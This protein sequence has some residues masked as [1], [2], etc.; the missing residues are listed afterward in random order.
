ML[1]FT[2][3]GRFNS[4]RSI[5]IGLY[6]IT[7]EPVTKEAYVIF[8]PP[9]SSLFDEARDRGYISAGFCPG[10]YGFM[11]KRV[12]AAGN[13]CIDMTGEGVRV[14]GQLLDASKAMKA[15]SAGRVMPHYS[16]SG[17]TLRNREMLLM[18]D[19]SATSFDG[20]YFGPVDVS[21]IRGVIRPV[22][23]W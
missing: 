21:Q 4:T 23:T 11:M 15:D 9:V 18:S 14:N 5:P 16:A 7:D 8:C 3:G 19:V 20:R 10:D 2:A 13:D 12:L 1:C 17:Y 6:W 22:L